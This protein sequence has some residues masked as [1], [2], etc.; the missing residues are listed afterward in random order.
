MCDC[1]NDFP[2][3]KNY[4]VLT[5]ADVKAACKK[6]AKPFTAVI[7]DELA[8][9]C[10]HIMEEE[11][12]ETIAVVMPSAVL[13]DGT[14][15]GEEYITPLSVPHLHWSCLLEGPNLTFP[16]PVKALID[17]GSHLV[18]IDESLIEKL[19]L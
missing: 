10:S 2:D 8:L 14:D 12:T 7:E 6:C 16:L 4:K 3:A 13:G 19:G 18:L 1:P 15:L 5:A 11:D 9:K 17:S